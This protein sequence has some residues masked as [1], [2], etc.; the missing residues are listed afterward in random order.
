MFGPL[1]KERYV[2]YA[3]DIHLSANHLLA[4]ISD[5]L[6]LAKAEAGKMT[7]DES[8]FDLCELATESMRMLQS[9]AATKGLE[10]SLQSP[11]TPL[12]LHADRRLV[13]QMLINVLAN[14][15]KFTPSGGKVEVT[16]SQA[17]DPGQGIRFAVK[18]TGPGM[19]REELKRCM[20]PFA[21]MAS[22]YTRNESGAGLGLPM[23][24]K[25]MTLHNGKFELHSAVG[26]GTTAIAWFP[27]S[28]SLA[29]SSAQDIANTIT[30]SK[31]PA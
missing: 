17:P 24:A 28:R 19:T 16:V 4:I 2:E 14:A 12:Y 18:D 30:K 23:V 5:I 29:Q 26:Q 10:F 31:Q 6:D 8:D 15:I 7:F 9:D 13:R 25:I 21:Q 20:E 22:A 11:D 27:Q 3:R 1:G